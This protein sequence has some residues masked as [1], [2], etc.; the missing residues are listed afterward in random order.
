MVY[1]PKKFPIEN[2]DVIKKFFEVCKNNDIYLFCCWS[3]CK[4][5]ID[6]CSWT[7]AMLLKYMCKIFN[8]SG[9]VRIDL[10]SKF[11]P[12]GSGPVGTYLFDLKTNKGLSIIHSYTN[13]EFCN[14]VYNQIEE[15]L[16][17]KQ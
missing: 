17:Q 6:S 15:A 14:K 9:L 5:Q 8:K 16:C 3:D 10:C 4:D 12:Q 11:R 2:V 7:Y 1:I 13:N